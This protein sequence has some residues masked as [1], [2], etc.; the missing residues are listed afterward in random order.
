MLY[1]E[2]KTKV[3]LALK[4]I[5]VSLYCLLV[6]IIRVLLYCLLVGRK[7]F[8]YSFELVDQNNYDRSIGTKVL[9]MVVRDLIFEVFLK[10]IFLS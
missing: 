1:S 4:T 2:N 3:V 9:M 7:M 10:E 6:K 8:P 5:R